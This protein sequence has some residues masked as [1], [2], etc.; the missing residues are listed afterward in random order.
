MEFLPIFLNISGRPCLV[1]GGGDVAARK[2]EIL[3]GAGAR[4]RVVAPA[5]CSGVSRQVERGSVEHH[6]GTFSE[7]D[8]DGCELVIAATDDAAV[9][10]QVAELA[11]SRRIPV[12]VVDDPELGS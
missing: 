1:V 5:L 11:R 8:L 7:T 3:R 2:I 12:N 4:V 10:R 9:N 6:A